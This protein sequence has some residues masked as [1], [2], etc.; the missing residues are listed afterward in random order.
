[1]TIIFILFS[2]GAGVE[3]LIVALAIIV[4][5]AFWGG[6]VFIPFWAVASIRIVDFVAR[7]ASL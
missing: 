3:I 2:G 4:H 7:K 1:M 5:P 6:L